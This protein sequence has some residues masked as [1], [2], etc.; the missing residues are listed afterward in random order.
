MSE[1]FSE[2][3]K[4]KR[5][6]LE[7]PVT[8]TIRETGRAFKCSTV[9]LSAGGM[10]VVMDEFIPLG[11]NIM[12]SF[13]VKEGLAF[14]N[15]TAKILRATDLEDRFQYGL[16]FL[17][18]SQQGAIKLNAIAETIYFIKKIKLFSVL[19]DAEALVL[20]SVGREINY[21]EGKTIF[22][23]GED[24]DAF[25]AVV[26]GKVRISKKSNIDSSNEEVLALIRE[27]EFFGEMA[28][29]DEGLRTANATAHT[30]CTLF[31]I[32]ADQFNELIKKHHLVAVKILVGFVS[33]LSKRLKAMSQ[34]MVDLL[35][36]EA[37]LN[38]IK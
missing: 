30:D 6:E 37:A 35:F 15:I 8:V 38:E 19:T 26:S 28:L 1:D 36:S 9:N 27:G 29:F 4:H 7:I 14:E 2:R 11:K 34:E 31:I 16:E 24:G 20:K 32:T 25:C 10:T 12:I 33:T 5:V 21:P 22:N 3:K 18:M 13:E 17:N 23:E